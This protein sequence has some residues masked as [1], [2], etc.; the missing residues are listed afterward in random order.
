MNPEDRDKKR[1]TLSCDETQLAVLV[2]GVEQAHCHRDLLT[3]K[4]R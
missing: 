4:A 1:Y 2:L 3:P